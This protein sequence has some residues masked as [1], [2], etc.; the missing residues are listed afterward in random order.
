MFTCSKG[1]FCTGST[2]ILVSLRNIFVG[3][4]TVLNLRRIFGVHLDFSTVCL[5]SNKSCLYC[6]KRK[7]MN[8]L[9]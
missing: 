8:I 2:Q 1:R 3:L 5:F 6:L 7:F 9:L 4:G